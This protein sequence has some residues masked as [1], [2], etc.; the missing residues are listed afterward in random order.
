MNKLVMVQAARP[1]VTIQLL[2]R[3]EALPPLDRAARELEAQFDIRFE[4][5]AVFSRNVLQELHSPGL[6]KSL[7]PGVTIM[8]EKSPILADLVR[9][10]TDLANQTALSPVDRTHYLEALLAIYDR[11]A[12][13]P[14]EVADSSKTLMV[15]VE[16]EG[17]ILA[18][19]TGCLLPGRGLRPQAKRIHFEGGL[20]V[21]LDGLG[22]PSGFDDCVII[23]GAIA[24]GATQITIMEHL[25]EYVTGFRV[26]SAHATLE[27]LR[28][29]GRY[30]AGADLD[31]S[32][33]V[34]HATSGLNDHF[35]ATLPDDPTRLV[36]GD[37]GDTISPVA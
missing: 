17:R 28:A 26:F 22:E 24:S 6:D 25:R 35:Y 30:A 5:L 31:L 23:D 18:E 15:G 7:H 21:G 36:V 29:I 4:T 11:L 8:S 37:L 3:A 34:G 1:E 9:R 16:R 12:F 14:S 27:G 19:R 33:T 13:N 20:I 10:L 32:L 2:N